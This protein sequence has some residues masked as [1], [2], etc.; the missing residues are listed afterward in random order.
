MNRPG[1]S[2]AGKYVGLGILLVS[3]VTLATFVFSFVGTILLGAVFGMMVGA[4]RRWQWWSL[5]VSLVFPAAL[6]ASLNVRKS[7]LTLRDSLVLSLVCLGAFWLLYL[8]TRGLLH[9][10]RQPEATPA[11]PQA[12]GTARQQEAEAAPAAPPNT[13][14]IEAAAPSAPV[15]AGSQTDLEEL[16]GT[17]ALEGFTLDGQACQK[18]IE[19][20]RDQLVLRINDLDGKVRFLCRGSVT[21]EKLGPFNSLKVT[22]LRSV[23]SVLPTGQ[24]V[25][26][27]TWLYK[28]AGDT[29]S[30]AANFDTAGP[31]APA[32]EV[33]TK[34]VPVPAM[35]ELPGLSANAAPAQSCPAALAS[36]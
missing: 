14:R 11:E 8:L 1:R 20:A 26:P 33:Y 28:V 23:P 22:D 31:G 13:G 21:L 35:G 34:K 6:M 7:G 9:F 18:L 25:R 15:P 3:F 5:P 4:G 27:G 16:Q 32:F 24:P 36:A 2:A 17:W 30:V 29:M 10:E 12:A 19:F